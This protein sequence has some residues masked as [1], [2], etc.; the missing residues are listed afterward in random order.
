MPVR[1]GGSYLVDPVTGD[2][3]PNPPADETGDTHTP[4]AT[5]PG[6]D[7]GTA[8]GAQGADLP[9]TDAPAGEIASSQR[10]KANKKDL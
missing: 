10:R 7:G 9:A 3:T 5:E 4:R 2:L 8:I 6:P 1:L